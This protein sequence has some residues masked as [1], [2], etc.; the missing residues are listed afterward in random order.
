M[1]EIVLLVAEIAVQGHTPLEE[2]Q[3]CS[4]AE[5]AVVV[6]H[7][8]RSQSSI[9]GLH[10]FIL[11]REVEVSHTVIQRGISGKACITGVFGIEYLAPFANDAVRH[12]FGSGV[13]S[14]ERSSRIGRQ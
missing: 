13:E 10:I 7:I 8:T 12:V 6:A 9:I 1:T 3:V 2:A 14:E 5:T 4:H 11:Q